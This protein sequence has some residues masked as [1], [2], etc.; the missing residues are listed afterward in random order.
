LEKSG[1][2]SQI[3]E[4][5]EKSTLSESGKITAANSGGKSHSLVNSTAFTQILSYLGPV[6]MRKM[7]LLSK[8]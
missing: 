6:E 1:R 8:G 3:I 4:M 5:V 7:R 2:K